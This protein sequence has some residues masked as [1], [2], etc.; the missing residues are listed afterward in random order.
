M[1]FLISD[2]LS[3]SARLGGGADEG[4]GGLEVSV[5][6]VLR[7][8][9]RACLWEVG[10]DD[11]PVPRNPREQRRKPPS[12]LLPPTP[13]VR[14]IPPDAAP[15]AA[16]WRELCGSCQAP[17]TAGVSG[18]QRKWLGNLT[19]SEAEASQ[20]SLDSLLA[21]R[22]TKA[23]GPRYVKSSEESTRRSQI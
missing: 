4:T 18:K 1:S 9:K 23:C 11:P 21:P 19:P 10:K 12:G 22:S 20:Q 17:G 16:G 8:Q 13:Q 6:K 14:E 5:R 3:H 7:S 15:D 2:S